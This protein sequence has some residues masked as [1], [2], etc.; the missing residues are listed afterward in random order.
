M[1]ETQNTFCG[2]GHHDKVFKPL[3]G[4]ITFLLLVLVIFVG[5]NAVLKIKEWRYVGLD[6]NARQT[7]SVSETG[8]V[9]AKPDLAITSFSVLTEALTVAE[10]MESNTQKMNAVIEAIKAEGVEDKDLKTTNFSI[11]PRYEYHDLSSSVYPSG[12]RVLVGYEVSQSL[13]VKIRDLAKVGQI[14]QVAT[15]KGSNQAG[16][17]QFT[18]EEQDALKQQA[19]EEAIAKAKTKAQ[20]LAQALGVKLVRITNFSESGEMPYYYGLEKSSAV[21]LG[22]GAAVP[23]IETGQNKIQVTVYLTYEIY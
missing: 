11:N 9:Y 2:K 19:R 20:N 7:I 10:A 23:Q 18:I 21:G 15:E 6:V 4:L 17:L 8:E 12:K 1:E 3:F 16:D 13:Q 22:G 14:V 5:A